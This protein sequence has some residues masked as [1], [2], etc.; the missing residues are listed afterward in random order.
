MTGQNL[1]K[2]KPSFYQYVC[3]W[4]LIDDQHDIIG[5]IFFKT[6]FFLKH[7]KGMGLHNFIEKRDEMI[8]IK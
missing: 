5:A 2:Y 1:G 7:K 4:S 3:Q 8:D 6:T